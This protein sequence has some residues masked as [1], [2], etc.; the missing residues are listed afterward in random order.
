[1]INLITP[2]L[3]LDENKMRANIARMDT[4]LGTLGVNLRPHV[5][6]NKSAEISSLMTEKHSGGITVSTLREARFFAASGFRDILYAVGITPGKLPEVAAL[7][8]QGTDLKI[9]LDSAEAASLVATWAT[10]TKS[11]FDILLEINT[12]DHRAGLE[13]GGDELLEA[14]KILLN[15]DYTDLLGVMT[16]AGASYDCHTVSAIRDIARQER[17]LSLLAADRLR[18]IGADIRCVSIGSTPT[19]MMAENLDGI[20]EIRAGV[21]VFSDLFQ[22]GLGIAKTEDIAIS[23]LTTVIG[24]KKDQNRL[25][26]DAGALALSKDN[27]TAR[28]T[29]DCGY[30]LVLDAESGVQI[31]NLFVKGV[32]QE[33][34]LISSID[35]SPLDFDAFPIGRQLR[36]LPN[37]ACMT[38]A[39]Y[40]TYAVFNDGEFSHLWG[41]CNGW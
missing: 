29:F 20:T 23:V 37:H 11:S 39:A 19:A 1:M 6:T 9:I 12:D 22:V 32:N 26:T 2:S 27:G 7:R 8:S 10:N 36:I 33:H 34:G 21:Y 15:C 3:I 31:P 35:G 30:G 4:H 38:A 25:I 17:D 14:G 28:Q 18:A 5:K 40:D 41:R 24:K 16:H 13:P